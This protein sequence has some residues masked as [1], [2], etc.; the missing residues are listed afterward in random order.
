M[1]KGFGVGSEFQFEIF[2]WVNLKLTNFENHFSVYRIDKKML[3]NL[4]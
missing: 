3:S 1:C 4:A 2:F